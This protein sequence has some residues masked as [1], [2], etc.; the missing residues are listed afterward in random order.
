MLDD[1]VRMALRYY[2]ECAN[3]DG[4]PSK[5]RAMAAAD[6]LLASDFVILYNGNRDEDGIR[7][8]ER[9][10]EFLVAHTRSFRG[11][12]WTVETI[13]ADDRTVACQWR[14]H[15]THTETGKPI[16]LRGADFLTVSDGRFTMLRRILDIK[17]LDE[18][19]PPNS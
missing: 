4:D 10:K 7:G 13:V 1:N 9:H 5:A 15:A 14:L 2:E 19:R 12:R 11:E 16:D 3:D 18:Q 17:T 6:E 8:I